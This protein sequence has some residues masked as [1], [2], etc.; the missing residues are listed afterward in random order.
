[1]YNSTADLQHTF[2]VKRGDRD[3]DRLTVNKS[4]VLVLRIWGRIMVDV[5]EHD[6]RFVCSFG[7]GIFEN[8]TISLLLMKTG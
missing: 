8:V 1:M 2:R 4:K 6:G 7:E 3:W 5:Y